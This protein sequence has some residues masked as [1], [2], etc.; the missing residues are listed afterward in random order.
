M[1]SDNKVI[2]IFY[3]TDDFCIFLTKQLKSIPLMME[4]SIGTSQVI[5]RFRDYHNSYHV[6]PWRIQMPE[7]LLYQLYMQALSSSFPQNSIL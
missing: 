1:L 7:I 3:M 4:G 6:S 5:V 2:E